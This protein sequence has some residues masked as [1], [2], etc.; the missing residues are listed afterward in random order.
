MILLFLFLVTL[1]Q[2]EDALI[3]GVVKDTATNAPLYGV[4]VGLISGESR[5]DGSMAFQTMTDDNGRF[6]ISARA[7]AYELVAQR[8]GYFGLPVNGV[9]AD[10]ASQRVVL[11]ARQQTSNITINLQPG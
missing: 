10:S 8:D 4:R 7:G 9:V 1:F 6:R 3:D 5:P 2:G 11:G